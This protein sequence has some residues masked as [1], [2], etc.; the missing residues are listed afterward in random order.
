M[1]ALHWHGVVTYGTAY[2]ESD[3]Q[4]DSASWYFYPGII[5][6]YLAFA[7]GVLFMVTY[8]YFFHPSG[9][10][11]KSFNPY[12]NRFAA[13]NKDK[14]EPSNSHDIQ[15]NTRISLESANVKPANERYQVKM[16]SLTEMETEVQRPTELHIQ[17]ENDASSSRAI[18]VTPSLSSPVLDHI[19]CLN[20]NENTTKNL[21]A[22]R[23][24]CT[25]E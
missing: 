5:G 21:N 2:S 7:A 25:L 15:N 3:L 1:W 9:N 4:T 18:C 14:Q 24:N 8:Y 6:H 13:A 22:T 11:N 10:I 17:V 12:S 19:D 23:I 20:D 16:S